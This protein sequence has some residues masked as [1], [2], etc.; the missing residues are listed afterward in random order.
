MRLQ[1]RQLMSVHAL[2][3][4]MY[5]FTTDDLMHSFRE[6]SDNFGTL[7]S[8]RKNRSQVILVKSREQHAES[9]HELNKLRSKLRLG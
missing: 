1:W 2:N 4:N 7:T 5:E 3:N 9:A 6:C 8:L